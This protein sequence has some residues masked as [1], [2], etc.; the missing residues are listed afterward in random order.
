MRET[1]ISVASSGD[2]SLL[3]TAKFTRS[4]VIN[5]LQRSSDSRH[6]VHSAQSSYG[7][8]FQSVHHS[9]NNNIFNNNNNIFFLWCSARSKIAHGSSQHIINE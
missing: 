9:G 1:T 2:V 7:E 3:G 6:F 8:Y 5:L 4:E